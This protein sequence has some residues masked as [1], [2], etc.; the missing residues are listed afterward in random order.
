MDNADSGLGVDLSAQIVI[1]MVS[2]VWCLLQTHVS[3]VAMKIDIKCLEST[4]KLIMYSLHSQAFIHFYSFNKYSMKITYGIYYFHL[5][6]LIK[7]LLKWEL[8]C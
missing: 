6:Y 5:V 7:L 2:E 8:L 3:A 1:I 4:I